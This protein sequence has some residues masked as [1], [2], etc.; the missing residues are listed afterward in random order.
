MGKTLLKWKYYFNKRL[1]IRNL[2]YIPHPLLRNGKLYCKGPT[3]NIL[4][5]VGHRIDLMQHHGSI[6]T[7]P[8]MSQSSLNRNSQIQPCYKKVN[9][10][11][12]KLQKDKYLGFHPYE[13]PRE[14]N[15]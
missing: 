8:G 12:T 13:I 3:V 6:V 7:S 10:K 14:S 1:Y 15:S 2:F 9:Y 4:G 11:K 5:F